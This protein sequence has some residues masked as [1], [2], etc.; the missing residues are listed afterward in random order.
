MKQNGIVELRIAEPIEDLEE[1]IKTH[2]Y[3]FW[4]RIIVTSLVLIMIVGG[5]YLLLTFKTYTQTKVVTTYGNESTTNSKYITFAN[6]ILKYGRDGVLLLNKK[7]EELW[8]QPYQIKTPII[9]ICGDTL[10]IGDSG[11]N[12][13]LVFEKDGL[14]GE[15]QT[16]LPIEEISVSAQG[17][18]AALLKNEEAPKI[19]CYDAKGNILVTHNKPVSDNG[20]PV[21]ISLSKKGTM[22]LVSYLYVENGTYSSK[23]AYYNFDKV[24]GDKTDNEVTTAEYKNSIMPTTFFLNDTTS[25]VIGDHSFVIYE[26]KQ[27]PEQKVE[28]KLNKEIESVVHTDNAIGFVLKNLKKGYELR[29]YDRNG[30]QKMSKNFTGEYSNIQM[31]DNQILMFDGRNCNIYSTNGVN[32]FKGELETSIQTIFPILGM[33]KYIVINANG[34]EEIRLVK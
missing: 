26:G 12:S 34:I 7:G 16:N 3:M 1:R 22:L 32:R 17:V 20:Y 30:K 28:V 8:N 10:A 15:I 33:N 13:I 27:I 5:T 18:V 25:V 24:G 23:I 9:D 29:I 6:G 31:I 2:K 21:G 19:I 4:K 14:K 11:G